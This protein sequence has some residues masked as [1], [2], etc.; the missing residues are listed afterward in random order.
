MN[1]CP[2]SISQFVFWAPATFLSQLCP[3]RWGSLLGGRWP[4]PC[5]FL[6][7]LETFLGTHQNVG[8]LLCTRPAEAG[9]LRI[10]LTQSSVHP[11][12]ISF[13]WERVDLLFPET[14]HASLCCSRHRGELGRC[15]DRGREKGHVWAL[16][17]KRRPG[18]GLHMSFRFQG[19]PREKASLQLL[20]VNLGDS[21]ACPHWQKQN[22]NCEC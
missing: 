15:W 19:V 3:W 5:I 8:S 16:Q 6:F 1:F 22:K 12:L 11:L 18:C 2:L 4:G 9:P 21:Q 20:G 10:W 7:D 13:S 14:S 17:S